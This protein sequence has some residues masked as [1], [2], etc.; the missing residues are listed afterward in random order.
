[1]ESN[2]IIVITGASSGIGLAAAKYFSANGD[3]VYG[4]SR[5][6]CPLEGV[7]HIACDVGDETSVNNAFDALNTAENG[8]IDV[9]VLNAGFG[10]SGAV[11]TTPTEQAIGQFNINFFGAARC[12]KYAAPFLRIAAKEARAKKSGKKRLPRILFTSSLAA[13]IPIPF[14]GFYSASKAAI[15]NLSRA[16]KA[17]LRPFKIGVAAVLP[18]DVKTGFT[19][20][21]VKNAAEESDI[22]SAKAERAV[23][24]ME[25]DER[26]GMPPERVGR[27]IFRLSGKRRLKPQYTA[28]FKYKLFLFLT[29]IL[30]ARLV[31]WVVKLMYLKKEGGR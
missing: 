23:A 11:E 31:D 6:A 9:L 4:L 5:T 12:V 1:M 13:V 14:Q 15:C 19:D 30:P 25:K 18:G 27:L 17:E 7:R 24:V 2:R 3:R 8:K 21:R 26:G 20:K 10:I 29:H 22:Y 28:G 16:L